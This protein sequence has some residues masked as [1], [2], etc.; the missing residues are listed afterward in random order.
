MKVGQERS[1]EVTSYPSD[2]LASITIVDRKVNINKYR[3]GE[4][5][6][7]ICLES[8]FKSGVG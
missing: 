2:I 8:S 1:W 5:S 6:G 3:G 7:G 4:K